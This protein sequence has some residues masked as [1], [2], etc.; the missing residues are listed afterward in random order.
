[1]KPFVVKKRIVTAP[2]AT[3]LPWG[4]FERI[5][6]VSSNDEERLVSAW[7]TRDDAREA[8]RQLNAEEPR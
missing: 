4:V 1:M 6:S 8:A 7:A 5:Q 3:R 2:A